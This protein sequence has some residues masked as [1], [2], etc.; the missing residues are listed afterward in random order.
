MNLNKLLTNLNPFKKRE[1]ETPTPPVVEESVEQEPKAEVAP[2]PKR[3][4]RNK[5]EMMNIAA[6]EKGGTWKLEEKDKSLIVSL[7]ASGLTPTEVVDRAREEFNIDI[8]WQQVLRY[9]KSEKWAPLIKKIRQ[10]TMMDLA[11]VAGSH[12]KVRLSRHETIYERALKKND[13]KHALAATEGQRKEMEGGGDSINLTL[14]QFNMLSDEELEEK[15]KEIMEKV[16]RLNK[17]AITIE[18]PTDKANPAGA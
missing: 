2:I 5:G 10:E 3:V 14:N 1:D 4:P 18:Q 6:Q 15:K 9:T 7:W 12:K 8:S 13:L 16:A 11:S 17:G